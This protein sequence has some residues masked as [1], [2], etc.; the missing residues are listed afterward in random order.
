MSNGNKFKKL[1]REQLKQSGDYQLVSL[2]LKAGRSPKASSPTIL[3]YNLVTPG[4]DRL[5]L[6]KN[7]SFCL[8]HGLLTRQPSGYAEHI[9]VESHQLCFIRGLS[10]NQQNPEIWKVDGQI[11]LPD[12]IESS[13]APFGDHPWTV[14]AKPCGN[15]VGSEV[16]WW[17]SSSRRRSSN[18]W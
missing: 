6:R 8:N 9:H 17:W 4:V 1:S 3:T 14:R 2:S 16:G 13:K 12:W 10:T 15:S 7:H 5:L 18:D 11:I